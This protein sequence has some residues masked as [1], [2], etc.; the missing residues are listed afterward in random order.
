MATSQ[1]DVRFTPNSGHSLGRLGCPLR[2]KI[3]HFSL[4]ARCPLWVK[5]RHRARGHTSQ[6]RRHGLPAAQW[7]GYRAQNYFQRR[8]CA[9]ASMRRAA[10]SGAITVADATGNLK[11]D[12]ARS[13]KRGPM[14]IDP[15]VALATS[16]GLASRTPNRTCD[17][18]SVC[19]LMTQSEH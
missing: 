17:C 2:A 5:S 8:R 1:R 11:V 9:K 10:I 16:L 15:A 6:S 18:S 3:R 13:T 12:K 19:P 4:H 14:R 7:R